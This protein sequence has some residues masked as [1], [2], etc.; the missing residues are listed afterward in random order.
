MCT[1]LC[2]VLYSVLYCNIGHRCA[3]TIRNPFYSFEIPNVISN[4]A[5]DFP[6]N[7][8]FFAVSYFLLLIPQNC[9]DEILISDVNSY[10][11]SLT[12]IYICLKTC[13]YKYVANFNFS[14]HVA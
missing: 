8:I 13:C 7:K 10:K 11:S 4:A 6:D 5:K 14:I 9:T 2:T 12:I 1:Y 3:Y